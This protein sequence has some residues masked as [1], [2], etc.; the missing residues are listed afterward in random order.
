MHRMQFTNLAAAAAGRPLVR[1]GVLFKPR[2][3]SQALAC[4]A[5]LHAPLAAGDAQAEQPPYVGRDSAPLYTEFLDRSFPFLEATVDLRGAPPARDPEN[6]VPRGVVLPLDDNIFVCFDTEL[7]RVAAI[8]EGDFI[9]PESMAMR[10]YA[11]PLRKSPG[12]QETL[13]RPEG[14][15]RVATGLYPGWQRQGDIDFNDPRSR[16]IDPSEI[17]RGPL[18]ASD[19][20][21]LGIHDVGSTAVL[22]YSVFGTSVRERFS[23]RRLGETIAV[24]RVLELG[25]S[26]ESLTLVLN[27]LGDQQTEPLPIASTRGEPRI[28]RGRYQTLFFRASPETRKILIAYPIDGRSIDQATLSAPNDRFPEKRSARWPAHVKSDLHHG[29]PQGAYAVDDIAIPYPNPWKR[30]IRPMAIDF[31]SNGDAAI[32]TYDGD[33][34]RISG[35][36]QEAPRWQR[37]GS[38]FNEPQSLR[39]RNDE[40]FVFS[41]LGITRLVD[42]D[43]DSETDYYE[44]FCNRFTQSAETRD[45]PLSLALRPDDSFLISKGGQQADARSLHGGRVLRVSPDGKQVAVF[46]SGMRNGYIATHPVTGMVTASDQQGHYVPSTP[47]HV[48]EEGDYMGHLPS[49]PPNPPEISE[50]VLWLPHRVAQSGIH[51]VWCLDERQGPLK[52]S[53]L[54]V[55]YYGSR[56]LKILMDPAFPIKAAAAFPLPVEFDTPLLKGAVNPLDGL[57]YF[58]GIQ[59]FGSISPRLEGICRL[60]PISESDGLPTRAQVF[61][62]G[63]LLEFASALEADDPTNPANYQLSSWTY[64][65]TDRYG[66]PQFS[67]DGSPGFDVRFVHSVLLSQDRRSVFLATEDMQPSMQLE[68]QFKQGSTYRPIFFTPGELTAFNASRYGFNPVSFDALFASEPTPREATTSGSIVSAAR[69][70]ELYTSFGCIGCH[71]TDGSTLGKTGPSWGKIYNRRRPLHGGGSIKATDDYLRSA[72]YEPSLHVVEGYGEDDDAGMPSYKGILS[73]ADVESL[74]LYIHSLR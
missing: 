71:S 56:L 28:V 47:L 36:T 72:I 39:I 2:P 4:L 9:S 58:V 19:G 65:R 55:D 23:T 61:K 29:K 3:I 63:V 42:R 53:L 6:L 49:A 69:G 32:S 44:M 1:P 73:E 30:R 24:V 74:I 10:S 54:Y 48:I 26:S 13:P 68:V 20:Q 66:S 57:P 62:E 34:Y 60:R 31:F 51:Q 22:E 21:W 7:L 40:V 52:D 27:D 67:D 41:R 14:E 43:G 59:I 46:A 45:F 12:G 15:V 11:D 38:G 35:L 18:P 64:L 37:I 70:Q 8:W 16:G 5:L 50:P 25:P 17:G 33:V